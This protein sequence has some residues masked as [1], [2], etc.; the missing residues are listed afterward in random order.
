MAAA[1]P[2]GA[3][4]VW[5]D[6]PV[7]DRTGLTGSYDF[8]LDFGRVGAT[9]G[10]RGGGATDENVVLVPLRDAVKDLGLALESGRAPF[11]I[12]VIDH[13]ERVPTEN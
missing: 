13:S 6:R 10:R 1:M 8:P 4:P 9:V 2:V 3:D 5:L 7:I 12:L 11:D